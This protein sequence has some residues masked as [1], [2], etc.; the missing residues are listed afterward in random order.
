MVTT[1][2]RDIYNTLLNEEGIAKNMHHVAKVSGKFALK[3]TP[4]A[5][6]GNQRFLS[7][8]AS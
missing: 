1:G 5:E 4:E 2:S 7:K 3:Q 6:K 8:K